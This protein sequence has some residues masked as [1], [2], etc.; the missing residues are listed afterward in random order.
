MCVTNWRKTLAMNKR[1]GLPFSLRSKV[2]RINWMSSKERLDRFDVYRKWYVSCL[3]SC[4][5]WLLRF[6][7]SCLIYSI[8][9][10]DVMWCVRVDLLQIVL[11]LLI[12]LIENLQITNSDKYEI[13]FK[14][15]GI[16]ISFKICWYSIKKCKQFLTLS[17]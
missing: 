7:C 3:L 1:Q 13:L 17:F 2:Q 4:S 8:L 14:K 12:E 6:H 9:E 16:V 11:L 5:T 15:I 10:C